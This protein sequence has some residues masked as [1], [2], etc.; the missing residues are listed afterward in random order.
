MLDLTGHQICKLCI[1]SP[2][3]SISLGN[4]LY[5]VQVSE[6]YLSESD[7]Q[8]TLQVYWNKVKCSSIG[9]WGCLDDW[10]EV[11]R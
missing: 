4:R 6:G 9:M 5:L 10:V 8:G 11:P 2:N 7:L 3:K 1:L